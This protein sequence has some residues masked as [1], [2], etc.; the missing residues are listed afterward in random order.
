[1]FFFG[2]LSSYLT[3]LLTGVV[4]FA[5]LN[6]EGFAAVEVDGAELAVEFKILRGVAEEVL[7][8]ELVLNLVEG[9]AE[10]VGVVAY[11][12]DAAASITGE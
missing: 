9:G 6:L 7:S 10:T 5:G 11:I 8:A 12:D 3:V 2:F 1:M 4:A